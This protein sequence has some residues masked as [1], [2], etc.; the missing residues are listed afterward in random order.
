MRI[1]TKKILQIWG[2]IPNPTEEFF[3]K[4]GVHPQKALR[5]MT[6]TPE[7]EAALIAREAAIVGGKWQIVS[8]NSSVAT[9]LTQ[10][11]SQ[12]HPI[13]IFRSILEA[14]WYGFT[15]LEHP[16][17]KRD[18]AWFFEKINALPCEWF[19]FNEQQQLIIAPSIES[20][21][22]T[23]FLHE[24]IGELQ[25]EGELVQYRASYSNP[26]GESQLARVFWPATWIRGDMELWASYIDRF[27]DDSILARTEISSPQK[28]QEL[29]QAILDF[30]SSG[31][32]V[33]EGSDQFSLLK[34]EKSSSAELFRSF[35]E[36]CVQQINK[37]ILGHAAALDTTS[38]K[39][40]NDQSLSLVRK[41]ITNDDK[42]LIA[43]IMN[44]LLRH[45]CVIN[46]WEL[47][48]FVWAP[49]E[50]DENYQIKRDQAIV[51]MG[52]ELS[53]KYIQ[54]TYHFDEYDVFKKQ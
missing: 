32:M 20:Y 27:G 35:H 44:R 24:N 47:A 19:R 50:I 7:I 3:F 48:Q 49:E 9:I 45:L 11:I 46:Q 40:G 38:G 53:T 41:D 17:I 8:K 13:R 12:I 33:V 36:V 37:L 4:N 21:D 26:Y 51:N 1:K 2:D 15:V 14:V 52:F 39:L 18:G 54:K 42:M 29:L 16:I 30:R 25:K 22:Q 5:D 10:N 34:S 43:E 31:G 6:Y 28:R 23:P